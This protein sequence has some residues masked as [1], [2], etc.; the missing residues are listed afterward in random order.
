MCN[1]QAGKS[2]SGWVVTGG[3]AESQGRCSAHLSILGTKSCCLISGHQ[4][5]HLLHHQGESSPAPGSGFPRKVAKVCVLVPA[6][7]LSQGT[8]VHLFSPLFELSQTFSNPDGLLHSTG[9]D[10]TVLG[11]LSPLLVPMPFPSLASLQQEFPSLPQQLPV[12]DRQTLCAHTN[13]AG[14]FINANPNTAD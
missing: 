8:G 1:P 2:P 9:N 10:K 5:G 12:Q 4:F 11:R 13:Q 6:F 14:M 7:H 3:T